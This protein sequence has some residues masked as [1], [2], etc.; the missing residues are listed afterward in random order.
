MLPPLPVVLP[1]VAVI[2]PPDPGIAPPELLV[3]P[4]LETPPNPE[5]VPPTLVVL[6]PVAV[7]PPDPK[8]PALVAL[9]PVAGVFP[10][11]PPLPPAESAAASALM[12]AGLLAVLF[13]HPKNPTTT[14][15]ANHTK[16][17]ERGREDTTIATLLKPVLLAT[18]DRGRR[19]FDLAAGSVS[20][21]VGVGV[22]GWEQ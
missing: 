13:P 5:V 12:P 1:P 8:P 15:G 2:R 18:E 4:V 14:A 22:A 16:R 19:L 20:R 3:P 21:A 11:M 7:T 17:R 10:P 9:P 6:P